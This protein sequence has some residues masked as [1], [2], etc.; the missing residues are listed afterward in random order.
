VCTF[1]AVCGIKLWLTWLSQLVPYYARIQA[2]QPAM[3]GNRIPSAE[4]VAQLSGAF[5]SEWNWA[6]NQMLR[7]WDQPP[8]R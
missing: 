3:W 2:S 5:V 4:G 8:S 7:H 6:L 1:E